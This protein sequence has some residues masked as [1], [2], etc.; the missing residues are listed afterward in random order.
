MSLSQSVA[1]LNTHIWILINNIFGLYGSKML[2]IPILCQ[3]A[4]FI[5]L[6][7]FSWFDLKYNEID[8]R[9]LYGFLGFSL[10]Y[11]I[12]IGKYS[13]LFAMGFILLIGLILWKF[14]AFEKADVIILPSLIPFLLGDA[15]NIFVGLWFFIIFFVIIGGLFIIACKFILKRKEVPF[16]PA[17]T[18][19][20]VVFE[21]FKFKWI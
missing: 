8:N 4:A 13:L 6:I 9:F 11:V 14:K 10:L 20:Y 1:I 3:I 7:W 21:I 16:I 17:I 19:V 18:L 12:I 2:S 5:F 15:P